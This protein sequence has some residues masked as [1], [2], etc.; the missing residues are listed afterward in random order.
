MSIVAPISGVALTDWGHGH[1]P[2][3]DETANGRK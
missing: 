3:P 2:V 1:P